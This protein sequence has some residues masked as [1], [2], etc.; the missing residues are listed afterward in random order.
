MIAHRTK[1][2]P[3]G[4]NGPKVAGTSNRY[5]ARDGKNEAAGEKI[6][7]IEV[8]EFG[9][10]SANPSFSDKR[11]RVTS[12]I[13]ACLRECDHD[14]RHTYPRNSC[15]LLGALVVVSPISA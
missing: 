6:L 11:V 5:K 7:S 14:L 1:D 3:R 2:L 10:G 9:E 4:F 12:G 13:D 15:P 8:T